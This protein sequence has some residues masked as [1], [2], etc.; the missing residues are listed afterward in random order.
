MPLYVDIQAVICNI[1]LLTAVFFHC[2]P[3]GPLRKTYVFSGQYVW[4]VS[5]SGYNTP[6]LIS[7][8]WKELPGSLGAAVHSQLTSKSYFLKGGYSSRFKKKISQGYDV[9][10][11]Q[12]I[13]AVFKE[14]ISSLCSFKEDKIWRYS[15][16]KLDHGFP[17]RLTNIPA[18]IDSSLYF[19]KNKKI[20]FFKVSAKDNISFNVF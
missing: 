4:T 19:N 13:I 16:F 20:I 17:K 12:D 3:A 14:Y 2:V 1:Y 11:W 15:G 6:V 10:C 9:K 18:N 7:A 8:L 5:S